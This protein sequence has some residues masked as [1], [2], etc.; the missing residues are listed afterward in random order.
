M[1]QIDIQVPRSNRG[2]GSVVTVNGIE[3]TSPREIVSHDS[4]LQELG[5]GRG[6]W[7]GGVRRQGGPYRAAG[8]CGRYVLV[9]QQW[10]GGGSAISGALRRWRHLQVA[11]AAAHRVLPPLS[12]LVLQQRVEV[13]DADLFEAALPAAAG[14]PGRR[15]RQPLAQRARPAK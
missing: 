7:R 3:A 14:A 12:L 8:Q 1:C 9:G 13:R 10:V 2:L 15:R 5:V 4:A 6:R 11:A